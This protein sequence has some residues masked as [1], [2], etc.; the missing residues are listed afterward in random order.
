MARMVEAVVEPSGRRKKK[1]GGFA[2]HRGIPDRTGGGGVI[3]SRSA[4]SVG[5]RGRR[6]L[7][8]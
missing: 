7:G 1:V 2:V 5:P 3:A 8:P 6:R 4:G